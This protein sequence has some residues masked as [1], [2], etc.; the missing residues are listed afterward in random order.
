MKEMQQDEDHSLED[1]SMD[2]DSN[3]RARQ[4]LWA[5]ATTKRPFPRRDGARAPPHFIGCELPARPT[6]VVS[7]SAGVWCVPTGNRCPVQ[8]RTLAPMLR[9]PRS[10]TK[11]PLL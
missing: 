8:A 9:G 2:G 10:S 6:R 3:D 7:V 4:G 11:V 1:T 5:P